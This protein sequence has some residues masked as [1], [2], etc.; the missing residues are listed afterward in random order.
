MVLGL[1][2]THLQSHVVS[3]GGGCS[4]GIRG[5]VIG[6]AVSIIGVF[7]FCLLENGVGDGILEGGGEDIVDVESVMIVVFV[8]PGTTD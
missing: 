4:A 7:D 6:N 8:V 2:K 3:A 1:R 5:W